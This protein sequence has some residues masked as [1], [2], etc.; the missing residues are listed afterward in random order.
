MDV[1][2]LERYLAVVR[3]GT[4]SGAAAALHIAQPSLSRQMRDLE[5]GLGATLFERGNRRITLTEEGMIL[6]RRAEEIVRLVRQAEREVA[7]AGSSVSG[8]VYIGAGESQ[9]FHVISQVVAR[10][11]ADHPD[12]R[13]HTVSG[14]TQDL[15][16][17][18]ANGLLDV[19]LVFSD[20]D[21]AL[22]QSVAVPDADAFGILM[23]KDDALAAKDSVTYDDLAGR[24]VL[25]SRAFMPA[26]EGS[27]ALRSLRIAGTYNLIYNASLMVEDGIGIA[28]AF[29]GL[30]NTGPESSL[31]FR[32]LEP[33]QQ[34]TGRVIWK[35]YQV[36]A[37]AAQ[38]FVDALKESL[39]R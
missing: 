19:A 2:D 28:L 26:A 29:G 24:P 12:I 36:F 22:Y 16:D 9:A 23:R 30:V 1:E 25:V 14:D 8:D 31:C 27:E 3:E 11:Q 39:V 20:F 38:L 32:P 7:E 35:K 17:Q 5:E 18:I 4:I 33:A 34:V 6:R 15:M 21:Q 13:F 10:V 37:P